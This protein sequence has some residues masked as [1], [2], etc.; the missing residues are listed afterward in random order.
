MDLKEI[1]DKIK[2]IDKK[3]KTQIG[4]LIILI[5]WSIG[6]FGYS[7]FVQWDNFNN[8]SKKTITKTITKKVVQKDE[9]NSKK[10]VKQ[11]TNMEEVNNKEDV[12]KVKSKD[13]NKI[14]NKII[15]KYFSQL[16]NEPIKINGSYQ[17]KKEENDLNKLAEL[18]WIKVLIKDKDGNIIPNEQKINILIQYVVNIPLNIIEFLKSN[19]EA[20]QTDKLVQGANIILDKNI[21]SNELK[22]YNIELYELNIKINEVNEKTKQVVLSLKVNWKVTDINIKFKIT[23]NI[24]LDEI[25]NQVILKDIKALFEK[26][27]NLIGTL[28]IDDYI[29]TKN[30]IQTKIKW[31]FMDYNFNIFI[32]KDWNSF[33]ISRI[34]KKWPLN[35]KMFL[36]DNNK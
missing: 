24:I 29:I 14:A 6:Y 26:N 10:N 25:K 19:P 31:K 11:K 17:I 15:Q 16:Y 4:I 22:K 7:Y 34:I 20:I 13:T 8:Q 1:Q 3:T 28:N 5:I 12:S 21:I 23:G 18:L 36:L 30:I 35:I 2:K 27:F 32:S 33:S 9:D